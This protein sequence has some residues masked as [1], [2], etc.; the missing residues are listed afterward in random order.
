MAADNSTP[1]RVKLTANRVRG[2]TCPPDKAQAFLWDAD[3][4][5]LG[6][7]VT[8]TEAGAYV[9]QFK[10][11]GKAARITIG[12]RDA[13]D[14]GQARAEARRL[15]VLVDQGADPRHEKQARAEAHAAKQAEVARQAVTLG[16]VWQCYVEERRDH[17]SESHRRDHATVIRAA[18]PD[19]L[20]K[21][22]PT[23]A[24]PLHPLMNVRLPELTAQHLKSWLADEST[25]R[26]AYARLAYALLRACLT[27]ASE[28]PEYTGLVNLDAI[29]SRAVKERLPGTRAKSDVLQREQLTAWFAEVHKISNPVIA[30]YLQAL[31]LTGARREEIAG[32]R[33]GDVDFQWNS[34]RISDKVEGERTIPLTPYVRALL[35]DL[36]RRNDTPP[37]VRQIKRLEDAGRVWKPSPWVFS[38]PTAAS[39]RMQEPRIQHTRAVSNAGLPHLTLH[40][41]RRSFGTL[42]EWVEV[43][44]GI[45]AQIQGHK[46]SATAEKHY[47]VRPL[48]LLR[49][50][51]TKIEGW[52][53][54]QAGIEQPAADEDGQVSMRRVK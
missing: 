29:K 41:L 48:D 4:P 11:H 53:L 8:R 13:W 19:K 15:K 36:K 14:I 25:K 38:S 35:L 7:R 22:K 1:S 30:A 24:G 47:R 17:W 3:A 9:F 40:G 23:P 16:D 43:P 28:Q 45:V 20:H 26:P 39:G 33:W 42:S 31:L 50:W 6:L 27:W 54:E 52:M 2:F 51:H 32:L 12:S 44:A 49:M 34:L 5:G 37:N 46:P 21:G 18:D 10:I